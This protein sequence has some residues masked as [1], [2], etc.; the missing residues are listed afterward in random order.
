MGVVGHV[1]KALF[2]R[3]APGVAVGVAVAD[4]H[5]VTSVDAQG[6]VGVAPRREHRQ[7]PGVGIQYEDLGR[8]RIPNTSTAECHP[9]SRL[10]ADIADV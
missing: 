2:E 7:R 6:D 9:N 1:E 10:F 3:Q 8:S 4:E 5:G